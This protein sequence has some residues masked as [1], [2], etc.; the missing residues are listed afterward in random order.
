VQLL[1]LSSPGGNGGVDIATAEKS[2][3]YF[4]ACSEEYY[5]VYSDTYYDV[6]TP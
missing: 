5:E 6:I 2:E 3:Q 4:S 1:Q